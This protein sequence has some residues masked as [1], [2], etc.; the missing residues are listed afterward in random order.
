M[1]WPI[2]TVAEM[3]ALEAAAFQAG[4]PEDRLQ[5]NAA[6]Q[7]ARVAAQLAPPSGRV[8]VLVGPGNNGR[9]AFLAGQLLAQRERLVFTYLG[10]RHAIHEHELAQ[11]GAE[12]QRWLQHGGSENLE[13]LREV[14]GLSCLAIDGLVGIGARGPLRPPLDLLARALNEASALGGLRVL[15]VDIPSGIDADSGEVPG[16]AVRAAVTVALGAVKAGTLRFPAAALAGQLAPAPI[17]LP[18]GADAACR[19]WLLDRASLAK[20]LPRRPLDAHKGTLGWVLVVGGSAEYVGAPILSA[21]AAARSGCGLVALAV[22]AHVQIAA[23]ATLPEA[24]YM[25]RDEHQ[26]PEQQAERVLARAAEFRA[27]LVGPG[28]GRDERSAQLVRQ[29]LV[30]LRDRS[31]R[32]AIVLD[33]DALNILARWPGWWEEIPPGGILTPH[34]GEM[35]RLTGRSAAEISRASWTA[36][37]EA[38]ARWGQVVVLKGA[39]TAVAEPGGLAWVYAG[40]NPGLATA[41]S[42]DVLAGLIAGLAAQ[43]AAPLDAARLGIIVHGLAAREIMD[44]QAWRSLLA[45][46]LLTEIPRVLAKLEEEQRG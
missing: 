36:A 12:G 23:A 2:V 31:P 8:V 1:S 41:G 34:A 9:D 5:A 45:S 20:L 15:S 25:L 24:T 11:L 29:L 27:I 32:P 35:A 37:Q 21:A 19:V 38:A 10:P 40:A 13:R 16:E 26:T 30:G 39:H 14:L 18:P 22:P 4:I 33:A 44:R 7:I 3:R 28:L 42:G 43:G 6:E 17:G 46:D